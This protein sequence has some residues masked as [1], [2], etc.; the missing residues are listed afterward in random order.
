MPVTTLPTIA[1][2]IPCATTAHRN[3]PLH[4]LVNDLTKRSETDG[5]LL[6]LI[7]SDGTQAIVRVAA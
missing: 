1:R 3:T 4:S 6:I 2:T 7:N 5:Q